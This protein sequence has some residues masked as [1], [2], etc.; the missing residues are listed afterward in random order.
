GGAGGKQ[1]IVQCRRDRSDRASTGTGRRPADGAGGGP[2]G[3]GDGVF[4]VYEQCRCVG[5]ADAGG[6]LD[7]A[8]ERSLT[9]A[10]VDANGIRVAPGRDVDID[11]DAAQYD[12]LRVS[13]QC[14]RDAVRNVRFYA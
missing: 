5:A 7:V 8:Q 14:G 12:Y 4:G 3:A 11:R 9:V 10:A 6:D 1:G 2:D 13:S